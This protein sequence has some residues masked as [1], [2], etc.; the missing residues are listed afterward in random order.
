MLSLHW[1]SGETPP[2]LGMAVSRK[3]DTRAVGRNRIKRVLRDAM[4]HLL[5]ELAGG[6]YVIVACSAAAKATNPQIRDA[7]VRLLR[8]AGALPLP[9]APGTM[10]PARAPRPSSL[11]PTEPDPRSD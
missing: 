5:P 8:R 3:V 9:A 1:R 11:S 7:F 6:D 2:R 4:R 10:P